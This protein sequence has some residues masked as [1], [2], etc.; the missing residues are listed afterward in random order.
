MANPQVHC[1][2]IEQE[3]GL[4]LYLLIDKMNQTLRHK[5]HQ[6]FPSDPK[7]LFS[8]LSAHQKTLKRCLR[9]G[10]I[11]QDQY[12]LLLPSNGLSDSV[13]FNMSLLKFLLRMLCGLP[14]PMTGWRAAPSPAD[15]TEYAHIE[16]LIGYRNVIKNP[17][18]QWDV[19][20]F[21]DLWDRIEETLIGLGCTKDELKELK[22]CPIFSNRVKELK[23]SD[24]LLNP[25]EDE[26]ER[27]ELSYFKHV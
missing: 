25:A 3:N 22:V 2:S 24:D 10:I 5:F 19:T 6:Y 7:M 26:V 9:N 15:Q 1:I 17:P 4:R 14:Q 27:C 23:G 16:R 20:K 8:A 21:N 13:T 12:T 11:K 18:L